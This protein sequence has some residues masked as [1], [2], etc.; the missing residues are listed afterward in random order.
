[1]S[2]NFPGV[3]F[4]SSV[5]KYIQ[6]K[7]NS[8]LC[9]QRLALKSFTVWCTFRAVVLLKK[10]VFC[11]CCHRCR[12]LKS[13]SGWR[14]HVT[15]F[16]LNPLGQLFKRGLVS[17]WQNRVL[18]HFQ[19]A[20]SFNLNTFYCQQLYESIIEQTRKAFIFLNWPTK[21]EIWGFKDLL[22]SG[23]SCTSFK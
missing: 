16:T 23:L 3:E 8:P 20:Q 4:L 13:R 2:A 1:M 19:F 10:I 15:L 12:S 11:S 7:G 9:V 5:S 14:R 22:N 18:S 21:E 6:R 17:V